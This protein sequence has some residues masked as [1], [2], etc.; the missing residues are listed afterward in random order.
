MMAEGGTYKLTAEL[1]CRDQAMRVA[2]ALQEFMEDTP[3][4]LTV[5]EH[6]ETPI[7]V[8]WWRIDAFYLDEQD[9]TAVHAEIEAVLG[10][11][12]P[13][14]AAS[15]VKEQNWV[16]I[17]QKSLP[18]VRAGRF[19]VHG[20]HDK[21]RVSKGPNSILIE[22]GEAFGTAHHP[23]TLGCLVA[24]D[25]LARRYSFDRILDLGC[26]SGIL[27][28]AAARVWPHARIVPVDIDARSVAV[29]GENAAINGLGN[30]L[31]PVCGSGPEGTEIG[32]HA[33]FRLIVANI[34]A[35]PLVA[36]A[37]RLRKVAA[38]GATAVL[39]GLLAHEAGPVAAAYRAHGF[40]L[41][42]RQLVDG[43]AVLTLTKRPV[44]PAR[45]PA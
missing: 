45:G 2:A 19:I 16:A 35:G 38:P 29:A 34:L 6:R 24:I 5:F 13:P 12:T 27:A 4:A 7:A 36:L 44:A 1:S 28:I 8:P 14:F 37:P 23:T 32:L 25:R 39:S 30:R 18:P 22:A 42:N 17:S 43:W 33:P 40:T 11:K 3:A 9:P 31:R 10:E 15:R 20:S 41:L 26:G 21:E